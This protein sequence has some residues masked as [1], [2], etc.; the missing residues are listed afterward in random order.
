MTLFAVLAAIASYSVG[1]AMGRWSYR[2][3]SETCRSVRKVARQ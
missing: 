3:E 1:I 2:I